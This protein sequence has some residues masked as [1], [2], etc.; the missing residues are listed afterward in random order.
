MDWEG[1]GEAWGEDLG[2]LEEETNGHG[3]IVTSDI[4]YIFFTSILL[5]KSL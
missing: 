2:D 1:K 3:N 5:K 4:S